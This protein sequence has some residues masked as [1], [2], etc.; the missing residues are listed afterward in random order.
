[1]VA[2]IASFSPDDCDGVPGVTPAGPQSNA[3]A[4]GGDAA[5]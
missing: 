5:G 2:L 4:A 1:M 3:T